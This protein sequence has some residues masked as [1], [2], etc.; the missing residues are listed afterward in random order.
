MKIYTTQEILNK[1]D[2]CIRYKIPFSH[3]R[4]GDGGIKFIHC[5]LN[6]D[7]EQ[8]EII[9]KKEG[10]PLSKIL[11][12]FELW[13]Y[14]AR[15]ADFIDTPEV[16]YNN[17]FWPRIKSVTKAINEETDIKMRTWKDLYYRSEFINE[18]YCNPESNCL[19]ILDI[20]TRKNLFDFMKDRKICIIC[21][22]P[23]IKFALK[24]YNIDVIKIVGQWENHYKCFDKVIREIK[25]R[26]KSYDFWLVAAGELGRIYT[27]VIKECG[28]RALDMGFVIDY[29]T[30]GYLHPRFYKFVLPSLVNKL[31]LRLTNE[32]KK[33]LEYI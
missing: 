10:L 12:I 19:F 28:G 27:G 1:L 24:N 29:W 31:E 15:K 17:S 2:W 21:T 23:E 22:K 14:Y 16:Y 11:E 20:P 6:K 18:N 9:V 5:V 30:D 13:G 33:Y 32:G 8:L 25:S 4:F 3:I 26:A 7:L